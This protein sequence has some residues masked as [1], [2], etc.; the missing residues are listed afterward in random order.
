MRFS[1]NLH[2]RLLRLNNACGLQRV[3]VKKGQLVTLGYELASFM[4]LLAFNVD[5]HVG[6]C[7]LA[8]VFAAKDNPNRF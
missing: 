2:L 3:N 8:G 6:F 1:L 7:C 5:F 4:G